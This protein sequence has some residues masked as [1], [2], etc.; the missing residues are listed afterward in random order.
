MASDRDAV[1]ELALRL[2]GGVAAW[3]EQAAVTDAV[4]SWVA[5]SLDKQDPT[6]RPVFVAE[7]AGRIVGFVTAGTRRHWAGDVDAYVG[8]LAVAADV[9]SRGL[10]RSLMSAA[11]AWARTKG[12]R[13]LIIETGAA[14]LDARAFY[15]ALGY[16]DEEVVLTRDLDQHAD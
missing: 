5:G 3:R 16:V 13:R 4:R 7:D 9:T 14:N 8:E 1:M 10:G 6:H 12:Y 2:T 15:A 11:E